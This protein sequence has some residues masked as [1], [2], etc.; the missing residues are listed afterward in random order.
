MANSFPNFSLLLFLL[1]AHLK[2]AMALSH[3]VELV[4]TNPQTLFALTNSN[5]EIFNQICLTEH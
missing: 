1:I 2:K 5:F 4:H 3:I